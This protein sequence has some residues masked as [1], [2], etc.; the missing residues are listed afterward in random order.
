MAAEF[1]SFPAPWREG[2]MHNDLWHFACE[3]YARP[4]ME[5]ACMAAQADGQEVC[6]VLCG[7]WLE[8]RKVAWCTAR[9]QALEGIALPWSQEVIQPLRALRQQ[10]RPAAQTD[11]ELTNIRN[12]VKQLELNAERTL[13]ARLQAVAQGWPGGETDQL[14]WLGEMVPSFA[15][16]AAVRA[17]Q[18]SV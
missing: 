4:G 12:S 6:L 11:D 13:L 16:Q 2:V 15:I 18:G 8:R 10:W 7:L 5:A 9:A 14:Q 17:A 1:T 3:L